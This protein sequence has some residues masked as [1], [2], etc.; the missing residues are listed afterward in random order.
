MAQ[1]SISFSQTES[2]H[3]STENLDNAS[4][5]TTFTPRPFCPSN[6]QCERL[7][8]N[9]LQ[10]IS[11]CNVTCNYGED[12]EMHVQ[13]YN[14]VPCLGDR[15]HTRMIPCMFCY[16]LPPEE[17]DCSTNTSCNSIGNYSTR[18]YR[19]TCHV[20]PSTLCLGKRQFYK[21]RLCHWTN[22]YSWTTT[23]LLSITL[24]GFGVDRFYLGY[25]KEG[26]GKLFSF[27]GLGV[28][29]I[30]DVILIS[31]GYVSPSDGSLYT[32]RVNLSTYS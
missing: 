22:G 4:V 26:L 16:Q 23:M 20:K 19:A 32:Y 10:E 9:C 30:V 3:I 28:W 5:T 31:I 7:D 29:T 13:V 17:Y 12:T 15:N 21:N 2:S 18:L 25:W 1:T 6:A 27:G 14:S 24:G 11:G 8:G